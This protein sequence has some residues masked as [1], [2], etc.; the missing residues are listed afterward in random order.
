MHCETEVPVLPVESRRE[1]HCHLRVFA[2]IYA[3]VVVVDYT[4]IVLVYVYTFQWLAVLV[5]HLL[6]EVE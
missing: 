4:V 2:V 3:A 6:K 1:T 5:V